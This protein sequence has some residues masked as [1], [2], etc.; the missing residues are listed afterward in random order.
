[1]KK[2]LEILNEVSFDPNKKNE[3]WK[4]S[5]ERELFKK[6]LNRTLNK[7][8][9]GY[10]RQEDESDVDFQKRVIAQNKKNFKIISENNKLFLLKLLLIIRNYSKSNGYPDVSKLNKIGF[11]NKKVHSYSFIVPFQNLVKM[12]TDEYK[13]YEDS[14]FINFLKDNNFSI[15]DQ[16][17][18]DF[19]IDDIKISWENNSIS[20]LSFFEIMS[21]ILADYRDYDS[22]YEFIDRGAESLK[23]FLTV[24]ES[25]ETDKEKKIK[26]KILNYSNLNQLESIIKKLINFDSQKNN[27]G[28]QNSIISTYKTLKDNYEKTKKRIDELEKK[29]FPNKEEQKKSLEEILE[30]NSSKFENFKNDI[31][32]ILKNDNKNNKQILSKHFSPKISE[33]ITNDILKELFNKNGELLDNL[34]TLKINKSE[35]KISFSGLVD[36]EIE[37]LSNLSEEKIIDVKISNA[38]QKLTPLVENIRINIDKKYSV[39]ENKKIIFSILN[40]NFGIERKTG[41]LDFIN[42]YKQFEVQYQKFAITFNDDFDKFKKLIKEIKTKGPIIYND[43]YSF[44]NSIVKDSENLANS[45]IQPLSTINRVSRFSG[46]LKTFEDKKH[47]DSFNMDISKIDISDYFVLITVDPT[48]V[49]TQSTFTDAWWSC[50]ELTAGRE[51]EYNAQVGSGFLVGNIAA[52]LLVPDYSKYHPGKI[53]PTKQTGINIDSYN[54]IKDIEKDSEH[55]WAKKIEEFRKFVNKGVMG[56]YRKDIVR[57][58][59]T[60]TLVPVAR[61]LIKTFQLSEDDYDISYARPEAVFAQ[62]KV[63]TL[64][65]TDSLYSASSRENDPREF[66]PTNK[67]GLS[68]KSEFGTV[69]LFFYNKINNLVRMLSFTSKPGQ[70]YLNPMQYDDGL[71]EVAMTKIKQKLYSKEK[72]IFSQCTTEELEDLANSDPNMYKYTTFRFAYFSKNEKNFVDISSTKVVSLDPFHPTN[73]P[74]G[75]GIPGYDIREELVDDSWKVDDN[76]RNDI[77]PFNVKIKDSEYNIKFKD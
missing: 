26:D 20:I 45:L 21:L 48:N 19:N 17:K 40:H 68:R 54:K 29:N 8:I 25:N 24:E 4:G 62:G 55:P 28:I 72:V 69:P 15:I 46:F 9:F 51:N 61:V 5:S 76:F 59:S 47:I 56:T 38:F 71:K 44:L 10:E 63:N 22:L 49:A 65:V 32:L 42:K 39:H 52:Y 57:F 14:I 2:F 7:N 33:L 11:L 70:Y 34:E 6:Q 35:K 75:P 36:E 1:M 58:L 12:Q 23:A 74:L 73:Y 53:T 43:N 67:K 18:K 27:S 37:F 3:K 30:K 16:T 31:S 77:K 64:K 50:Q 60:F 66:F 41:F 13:I